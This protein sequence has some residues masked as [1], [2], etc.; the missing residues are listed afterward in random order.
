MFL[1]VLGLILIAVG[2]FRYGFGD[3]LSLAM[4]IGGLVIVLLSARWMV[5]DEVR[6][7]LQRTP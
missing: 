1:A 7:I 2:L 5:R 3:S 4:A 6:D